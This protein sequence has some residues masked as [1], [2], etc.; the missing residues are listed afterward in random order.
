M[1]AII[2]KYDEERHDYIVEDLDDDRHLVIKESQL[3]NLKI[4]L[5]K[6]REEERR[7]GFLA[8]RIVGPGR[9]T[10]AAR[11]IGIRIVTRNAL[12]SSVISCHA[13]S[14]VDISTRDEITHPHHWLGFPGSVATILS[15]ANYR[16]EECES[17]HHLPTTARL[18][19]YVWSLPVQ[20]K[21]P[22][23]SLEQLYW[24]IGKHGLGWIHFSDTC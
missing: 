4:R 10:Y 14:L 20:E 5:G 16:F 9:Q 2:L 19:L 23:D 11:R 1:K 24:M 13:L 12:P 22:D 3:Q 7:A 6:V 17:T 21:P 15:T 8:D 18:S